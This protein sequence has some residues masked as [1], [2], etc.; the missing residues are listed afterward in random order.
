VDLDNCDKL[1]FSPKFY[2]VWSET[3]RGQETRDVHAIISCRFVLRKYSESHHFNWK[4]LESLDL[5]V[6]Y[7]IS[8]LLFLHPSARLNLTEG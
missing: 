7:I 2:G 3:L 1:P 5:D 8:S 4:G 6:P